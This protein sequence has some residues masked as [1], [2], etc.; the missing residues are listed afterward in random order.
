M[1]TTTNR[2]AILLLAAGQS[3]RFGDNKMLADIQGQPL[4]SHS[5]ATLSELPDCDILTVLGARHQQLQAILGEQASLV[6]SDYALG[7]G[8]SIACG[9]GALLA[10]TYRYPAVLIAL[11]DQVALTA[12]DY[13]KLIATYQSGHPIAAAH[14]HNR[15]GAPAIFDRHYWPELQQL[16]GD[17]GARSL[18]A[19]HRNRVAPVTMEK[20]AQDID[21]KQDLANFLSP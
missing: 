1:S 15:L 18:L 19:H 6:C 4:L 13:R 20:A 7:M 11:A 17:Q 12:R 16:T 5:L 3:S 10:S 21:V 8:H 2:I 14:Y 9:V